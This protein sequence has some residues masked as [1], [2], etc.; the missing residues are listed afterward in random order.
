MH[1]FKIGDIVEWFIEW[2]GRP[3]KKQ[4]SK[5]TGFTTINKKPC[6]LVEHIVIMTDKNK[7]FVSSYKSEKA[8]EIT[9]IKYIGNCGIYPVTNTYIHYMQD[10]INKAIDVIKTH[11]VDKVQELKNQGC[12]IEWVS[13]EC[14]NVL[15][16]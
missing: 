5:I 1:D 7:N 6:V 13:V 12:K 3:E 15:F 10:G 14:N 9:K 4:T 11:V 16:N 2:N 8:V